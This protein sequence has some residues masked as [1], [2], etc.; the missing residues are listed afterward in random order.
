[1]Q[2]EAYPT[3]EGIDLT[4]EGRGLYSV[5]ASLR[6]SCGLVFKELT[7]PQEAKELLADKDRGVT[8]YPKRFLHHP[9]AKTRPLPALRFLSILGDR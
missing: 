8:R 1:M 6:C 7:N 4:E 9:E 3:L 2:C 5:W